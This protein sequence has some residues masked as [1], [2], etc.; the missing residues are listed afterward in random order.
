[1]PP[2]QAAGKG[3]DTG[4]GADV[5]SLGAVL[6][7]LVT[8]RAPF[9]GASV[10]EVLR[11]VTEQEAVAP[12][13]LNPLVPRDLETICLKCLNKDVAARYPDAAALAEDLGRF[14]RHEP[15]VARP[16]SRGERLAPLVPPQPDGSLA[17][18]QRWRC[19]SSW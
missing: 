17:D 6:Y 5:Y 9:T 11:Q 14:L 4:M 16:V 19:C 2:E 18:R 15:I 8:G 3:S 1:M 13:L 12:S 7:H 10:P